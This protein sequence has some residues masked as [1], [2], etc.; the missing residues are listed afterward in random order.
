MG[1]KKMECVT[2]KEAINQVE[3]ILVMKH[4][5]REDIERAQKYIQSAR[6]FLVFDRKGLAGPP[7]ICRDTLHVHDDRTISCMESRKVLRASIAEPNGS[8]QELA[9]GLSYDDQVIFCESC[10]KKCAETLA[11]LEEELKRLM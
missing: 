5:A 2:L 4:K 7:V 10:Q 6:V 1:G 8:S 11:R 3:R 9:S